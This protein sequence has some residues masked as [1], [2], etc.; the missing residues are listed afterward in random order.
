MIVHMVTVFSKD[1]STE[2]TFGINVNQSRKNLVNIINYLKGN[3]IN[4]SHM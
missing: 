1:S 2:I 4:P 3:A